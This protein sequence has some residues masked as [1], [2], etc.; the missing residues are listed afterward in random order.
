M[1]SGILFVLIA[2]SASAQNSGRALLPQ[3]ACGPMD[4]QFQTKVES[5]SHADPH[6]ESGKALVYVIED[7]RFKGAKEVTVRIG[8]DGAWVGATRG[9]SYLFF[10]AEPGEHHLCGNVTPGVLSSGRTTSLFGLTTEA[11]KT[12]YLRA[13]TTGGPSSALEHN[14]LNDMLSIDLDLVNKDEGKFLVASSP[15]SVSHPRN[16]KDIKK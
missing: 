14:G 7:Q 12:Y 6:V 9:D 16:S 4:V 5:G 8:L 10:A 13:R 1:R 2:V 15:V 3:G 11:G